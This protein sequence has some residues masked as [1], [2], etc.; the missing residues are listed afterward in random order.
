[1]KNNKL[2]LSGTILAEQLELPYGSHSASD[3]QYYFE[4][5]VNTLPIQIDVNQ[6]NELHLKWYK[7]IFF[8]FYHLKVWKNL[9][10]KKESQKKDKN[11]NV[12][13][14]LGIFDAALVLCNL[15]NNTYQHDS[16]ALHTSSSNK[17]F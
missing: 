12:V 9:K 5:I 7:D 17:S 14:Q 1:M 8:N 11:G 3:I 10:I 6:K 4:Y 2:K 16:R 13:P 15:V